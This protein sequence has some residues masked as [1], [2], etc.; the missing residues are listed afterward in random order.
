[1]KVNSKYTDREFINLIS[2]LFSRTNFALEELVSQLRDTYLYDCNDKEIF[3]RIEAHYKR[4]YNWSFK[5]QFNY[6]HHIKQIN[7]KRNATYNSF[8]NW[9]DY[10]NRIVDVIITLNSEKTHQLQQWMDAL[11]N[12]EKFIKKMEKGLDLALKNNW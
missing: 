4:L 9:A 6:L 8:N 2:D 7:D 1:M 10:C 3:N 12:A 11:E 5:N